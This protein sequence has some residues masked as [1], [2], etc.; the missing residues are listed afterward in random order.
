MNWF[1]CVSCCMFQVQSKGTDAAGNMASN[2]LAN[3][4]EHMGNDSKKFLPD[5]VDEFFCNDYGTWELFEC[6]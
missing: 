6:S 2:S 5:F 4:A 3:V 1:M